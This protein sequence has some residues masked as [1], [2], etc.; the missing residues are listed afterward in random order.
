M[1]WSVV[2]AV[3]TGIWST[4]FVVA[5]VVSAHGEPLSF[6]SLRYAVAI[7]VLAPAAL[8]M[9]A[10][11]PSTPQAWLQAMLSGVLLHGAYQGAN[12]WAIQHGL[13]AGI[14]ALIGALQPLLTALAA[15]SLLGERLS[16][17]RWCGVALGFVGVAVVLGPKLDGAAALAAFGTPVAFAVI[18]TITITAATFYQKRALADFDLRALVP[19]Q[20]VGAALFTA[21]LALLLETPRFDPTP[22]MLVALGWAVLGLS[23][24]APVMMMLMIARGDVSRV[25]ALMYLI[26]PL[27]SLQAYALFG[28][29]LSAVQFL[30]MAIAAVGVLLANRQDRAAVPSAAHQAR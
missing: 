3:F 6:L 17:T 23:I 19:I 30:G 13:P 20:F 21:P 7:A 5:G 29:T 14:A 2:P 4:G 22:D 28:E 8:L 27:T 26:P 15:G 24:C 16:P 12:Y 11:W 10:R 25:A 18:A 1:I 9:R